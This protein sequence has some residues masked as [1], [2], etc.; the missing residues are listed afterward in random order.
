VKTDET[1]PAVEPTDGSAASRQAGRSRP[2][3]APRAMAQPVV[4]LILLGFV[5]L[6]LPS[7]FSQYYIDASTQVAIYAIVAAGL[8]L[9]VGRVGMVS[10]GQAAVLAIS[11]GVP[12]AARPQPPYAPAWPLA[13]RRRRVP[14][15]QLVPKRVACPAL[16]GARDRTTT[17]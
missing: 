1:T 15:Q 17:V 9:L 11:F 4:V 3:V 6:I 14:P 7:L 2:S 10:L 13:Q 5:L 8:G 16:L 12:S